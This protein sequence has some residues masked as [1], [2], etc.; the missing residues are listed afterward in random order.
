[1]PR[2]EE[3]PKSHFQEKNGVSISAVSPPLVASDSVVVA[4]VTVVAVPCPTFHREIRST[5]Y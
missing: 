3:C 1:M 5:C 4:V 2:V